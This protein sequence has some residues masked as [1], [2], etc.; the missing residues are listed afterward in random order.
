MPE[1]HLPSHPQW[2]H[3][4]PLKLFI[5]TAI[6]LVDSS[7]NLL[8]SI[9]ELVRKI[10]MW[11]SPAPYSVQT[12]VLIDGSPAPVNR[13]LY[14][15][16]VPDPWGGSLRIN[17]DCFFW[18]PQHFPCITANQVCCNALK[19]QR[20]NQRDGRTHAGYCMSFLHRMVTVDLLY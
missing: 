11:R 13:N 8:N 7:K 9:N 17:T 16:S 18:C 2:M 15:V 3:L 19:S 12:E 1:S 5:M 10:F 4:I 14:H 6:S 20:R